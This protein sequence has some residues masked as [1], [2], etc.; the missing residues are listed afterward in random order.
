M[1]NIERKEVKT[2]EPVWTTAIGERISVSKITDLHLDNIY[3]HLCDRRENLDEWIKIISNEI[4]KRETSFREEQKVL[5]E[6]RLRYTKFIEKCFVGHSYNGCYV[7]YQ[8]K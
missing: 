1:G 3:K 4:L 6:L 5:K 2:K 8:I 7:G